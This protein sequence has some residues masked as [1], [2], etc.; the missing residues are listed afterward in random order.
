MPGPLAFVV[1]WV[2]ALAVGVGFV[3]LVVGGG[4]AWLLLLALPAAALGLL[5]VFTRDR[6][7]V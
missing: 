7:G 5:M 2:V 4:F 3:L 1:F 6:G